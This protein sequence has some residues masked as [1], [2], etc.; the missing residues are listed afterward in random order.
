MA[1]TLLEEKADRLVEAWR[2]V[3]PDH[4]NAVAVEVLRDASAWEA[5]AVRELFQRKLKDLVTWRA[6]DLR[7]SSRQSEPR[8][9]CGMATEWECRLDVRGEIKTV[10]V[11]V[12]DRSMKQAAAE[13]KAIK[14]QPDWNN[15][16]R[17]LHSLLLRDVPG[18]EIVG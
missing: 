8:G 2:A 7:L 5:R 15:G 3:G 14:A 10:I 16:V 11:T 6:S 13:V 9:D 1:S 12:D 4:A 17:C 18:E